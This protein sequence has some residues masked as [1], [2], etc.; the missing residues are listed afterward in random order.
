MYS[1]FNLGQN[2]SSGPSPSFKL[3]QD[4]KVRKNETRRLESYALSLSCSI[5]KA[6][7]IFCEAKDDTM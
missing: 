2:I 3:N 7:C 6:L 4:A 1:A 5:F